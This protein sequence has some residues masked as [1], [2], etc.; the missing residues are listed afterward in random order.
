M[1]SGSG[2]SGTCS[3]LAGRIGG[4]S[5][6][7]CRVGTSGTPSSKPTPHSGQILDP[8]G[9]RVPHSGH[10][11]ISSSCFVVF[12]RGTPH[13]GH[14]VSLPSSLTAHRGQRWTA[15]GRTVLGISLCRKSSASSSDLRVSRERFPPTCWSSVAQTGHFETPL[16]TLLPH[17]GHSITEL[18]VNVSAPEGERVRSYLAGPACQRAS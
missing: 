6:W 1:I 5:S 13:R 17:S 9:A 16:G 12:A 3:G 14:F 18:S 2:R 15:S 10:S 11:S 8:I 4:G 7:I